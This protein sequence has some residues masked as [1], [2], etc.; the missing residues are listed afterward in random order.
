MLNAIFVRG[1]GDV[2]QL[3]NCPGS[4]PRMYVLP[5]TPP[6]QAS[7]AGCPQA[8]VVLDSTVGLEKAIFLPPDLKGA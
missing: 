4:L 5:A 1:G 3:H 8:F 6:H 7:D 2:A